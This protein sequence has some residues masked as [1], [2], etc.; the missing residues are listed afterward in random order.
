MS[1]NSNQKI[2]T[3]KVFLFKILDMRESK[4][5]LFKETISFKEHS[6]NSMGK[7]WEKVVNW[8]VLRFQLQ[9]LSSPQII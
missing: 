6:L 7:I 4:S 2:G 5:G 9:F 1:I 8:N 3:L